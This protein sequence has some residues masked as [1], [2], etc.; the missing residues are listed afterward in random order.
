M[1]EL[2]EERLALKRQLNSKDGR[3][4]MMF[5]ILILQFNDSI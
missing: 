3:G 2:E 5:D 1:R 4:K